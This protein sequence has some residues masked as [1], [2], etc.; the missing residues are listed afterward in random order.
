[1]TTINTK[2]ANV[3]LRWLTAS[4][5][6][7]L[8]AWIEEAMDAVMPRW[9]RDPQS[10]SVKVG[11]ATEQH[12]AA[13]NLY[14]VTSQG[15][16]AAVL[17]LE[18]DALRYLLNLPVGV[19]VNVNDAESFMARMEIDFVT[20]LSRQLLGRLST[21]PL[22][23]RRATL[24]DIKLPGTKQS[25]QFF[26]VLVDGCHHVGQIEVAS[27]II[28]RMIKRPPSMPAADLLARRNAI[29]TE[30]VELNAAIGHVEL[31]FS[32]LREVAVGDV[33]MLNE[34]LT[35]LVKL[36]TC[37]GVKFAEAMLGRRENKVALQISSVVAPTSII[38]RS[39]Q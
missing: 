6:E 15:V 12:L 32:E 8:R 3:P 33:L 9:R 4:Q 25:R 31:P 18:L 11:I 39:I 14:C 28:N 1:M 36:S 34:S 29:G 13:G 35:A 2:V 38:K 30:H 7:Q 27:S 5:R 24:S 17:Y 26:N 37:T 10:S 19:M 21:E 16:T 20:D 22:S 23:V